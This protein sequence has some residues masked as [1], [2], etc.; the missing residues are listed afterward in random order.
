MANI[1]IADTKATIQFDCLGTPTH[2]RVS[3]SNDFTGAVWA[4]FINQD[5]IIDYPLNEFKAYNLFLQVKSSVM[6]SNIKTVTFDRIDD[7]VAVNLKVVILNNGISETNINNI[8]ITLQ[9][10]GVPKFFKYSINPELLE[11]EVQWD[12]IEWVDFNSFPEAFYIGGNDGNK[13]IYILLKDEREVISENNSSIMFYNPA[14]PVLVDVSYENKTVDGSVTITP[15]YSGIAN[16]YSCE[17][18]GYDPIWKTFN[19]SFD[20]EILESGVNNYKLILRNQFGNSEPL[21]I[22]ITYDPPAFDISEVLIN[23]GEPDTDSTELSITFTTLGIESVSQY[24]ISDNE[25]DLE[26]SEWLDYVSQPLLYSINSQLS[27]TVSVYLQLKSNLGNIS[28]IVA[29]SIEYYALGSSLVKIISQGGNDDYMTFEGKT[30]TYSRIAYSNKFDVYDY[31][32]AEKLLD[33][34]IMNDAETISEFGGA[35]ETPGDV[36]SSAF[37]EGHPYRDGHRWYGN[38][39]KP[40]LYYG[41]YV[42]NGTYKVSFLVSF[43]EP[44]SINAYSRSLSVNGVD[45]TLPAIPISSNTQ[46]V[47]L[48]NHYVSDGKL[49][50][51]LGVRDNKA[52]GFNGITI[53]KISDHEIIQFNIDTLTINNNNEVKTTTDIPVTFTTVGEESVSYYRIAESK[54]NLSVEEWVP[55]LS[56]PILYNLVTNNFISG[57]R[58]YLQLKSNLGNI[59]N[60]KY[61]TIIEYEDAVT[62]SISCQDELSANNLNLTIPPLKYNKEN[63]IGYSLDDNKLAYYCV[64]FA[65]INNRPIMYNQPSTVWGTYGANLYHANNLPPEEHLVRLNKTIGYTDGC[66]NERR[67][68]LGYAIWDSELDMLIDGS[69]TNEFRYMHPYITWD[70]IKDVIE[71]GSTIQIHNAPEP[72][73]TVEEIVESYQVFRD[74]ALSHVGRGFKTTTRPD[75]NSNYVFASLKFPEHLCMAV[76]TN[77][78]GYIHTPY[79]PYTTESMYKMLVTRTFSDDIQNYYNAVATEMAKPKEQRVLLNFGEHNTQIDYVNFIVWLNDTYGKDGTDVLWLT[80]LDEVYE[81]WFM[82]NF[83]EI[84]KTVNGNIATFEVKLPKGQYFY[85]PELT[86]ISNQNIS[87]VSNVHDKIRGLSFNGTNMFNIN[88]DAN[89]VSLAEKYTARFEANELSIDKQD[90]LY[91]ANQLRNDLK[92]PFLSRIDA[93][94]NVPLESLSI[95]GGNVTDLLIGETTQLTAVF[96]PSDTVQTNIEWSVNDEEIATVDSNGLVTCMGAG[97]LRV[98]LQSIDNPTIHAEKEI[99]CVASRPITGIAISGESTGT[100]DNEIQLTAILSP[101]N[102]TETSILWESENDTIAHVSETGLVT[103]KSV[104]TVKI[105]ATSLSNELVYDELI[106]T[107][108]A[109]AIPVVSIAVNGTTTIEVGNTEQFSVTYNPNNTTELGVIW[110][111]SNQSVAT[112]NSSGL[113]TAI[114]P[115]TATITATSIYRQVVASIKEI[116]ITPQVIAITGLTITGETAVDNGSTLQLGIEYTP[117][118]TTQQEVTWSSSDET[119]ATV[120]SSGLV[121]AIAEGSVVITAISTINEAISDIHNITINEVV[122]SY[123]E[124]NLMGEDS[125]LGFKEIYEGKVYQ[126]C[127]TDGKENSSQTKTLYDTNTDTILSGWSIMDNTQRVA[128]FGSAGDD[129]LSVDN[130]NYNGVS[131]LRSY[132][133]AGAYQAIKNCYYGLNLPNGTYRVTIMQSVTN[134]AADSDWGPLPNMGQLLIND[135]AYNMPNIHPNE[136]TQWG[137]SQDYIVTDGKL[138]FKF[139]TNSNKYFGFSCINIKKIA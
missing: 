41:L 64:G 90:A 46:F 99:L 18:T 114:G 76:E 139:I 80:H 96:T 86:F 58:L 50:L 137:E 56:Q 34:R 33:W 28:S 135:T 77:Q 84:T 42:P 130:A 55:Y 103:L 126:V 89:L 85:Y 136:N 13:I 38:D 104:G 48:G 95:S 68:K 15:E 122:Q 57:S 3:E 118:N 29:D 78:D 112:V 14:P 49:K 72:N 20:L 91:F 25:T 27:G 127:N 39:D 61:K 120:N 100:V 9:Y 124:V 87:G 60:V 45:I 132:R 106:I 17:L 21:E 65:A 108:A 97:E 32:S 109:E 52:F 23:N 6:E 129:F 1:K 11:G 73:D 75:G 113:V 119:K 111:S 67:M 98:T 83:S 110:T 30:Y 8:P 54:E 131:Y 82:R 115:G 93:V 123:P 53:E 19:S 22:Q 47:D 105:I 62:F 71:F 37:P 43:D 107:V 101:N 94:E 24:K 63:I 35:G 2:Y 69:S 79:N 88:L 36:T 81:Y 5:L 117:S 74:L 31:N 44:G 138:L 16:E 133:H 134:R 10:D 116:T 59:S 121:T 7:Y 12:V 51:I 66:G 92:Q 4:S 40:W 128:A 26:T 70:E 125:L 102:T